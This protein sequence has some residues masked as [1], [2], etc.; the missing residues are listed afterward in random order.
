[1]AERASEQAKAACDADLAYYDLT[2]EEREARTREWWAERKRKAGDLVERGKRGYAALQGWGKVET[3]E[4]WDAIQEQTAEDW[5][6]GVLLLKLMGAERYLDPERMAL[7][8]F[9]CGH[10]V[11]EHQ[12]EGPAEY[13]AIA[14]ALIA[15]HHSLRLNEYVGNLATR[16]EYA[17]FDGE[18][19]K[20]TVAAGR[21]HLGLPRE[22]ARV[23][24]EE[25]I[26]A[27]GRE[28][29]PLLD[30][31]QRMVYRNLKMLDQ[32]QARRQSRDAGEPGREAPAEPVPI[33][34]RRRA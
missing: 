31:C 20:V 33:T 34:R 18:P 6:S 26:Q 27:L 11:A 17:A 2:P 13:M 1:M 32:F 21:D 23:V 7:L 28:A 3:P 25:A 9:L 5:H 12:P 24:G 16:A 30:L 22:V 29:L 19:P 14:G 10:F 15:F 8:Q 4:Q